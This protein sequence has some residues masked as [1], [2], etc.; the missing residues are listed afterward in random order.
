MD[1]FNGLPKP[2]KVEATL[3]TNENGSE[4]KRNWYKSY[5]YVIGVMLYLESN[6][7]P[8]ISFDVHQCAHFTHNT[9]AS[10]ETAVKSYMLLYTRY[11]G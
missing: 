11:Q 8:Y 1:F 6:T 5:A 7:Q 9:K 2:T 4:A 3:G 10:Q